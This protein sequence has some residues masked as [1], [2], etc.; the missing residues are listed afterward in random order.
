MTGTLTQQVG[1]GLLCASV[2]FF[3]IYG[4]VAFS[5]RL[6]RRRRHRDQR[7]EYVPPRMPRGRL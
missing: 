3:V 4:T 2:A 7:G 6:N 1:M 5:E